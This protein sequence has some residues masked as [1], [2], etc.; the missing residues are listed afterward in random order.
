MRSAAQQRAHATRSTLRVVATRRRYLQVAIA[1]RQR[2]D[3]A[4]TR[5]ASVAAR[6]RGRAMRSVRSALTRCCRFL[7][8]PPTL[9]RRARRAA[10]CGAA[11]LPRRCLL[12]HASLARYVYFM[13]LTPR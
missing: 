3:S 11:S 13:S 9:P 2:R 10:L 5:G 8:T 12:R 4:S 6:A 7:L 1:M